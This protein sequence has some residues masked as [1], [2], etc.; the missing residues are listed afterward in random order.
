[1]VPSAVLLCAQA[2]GGKPKLSAV[3]EI[4]KKKGMDCNIVFLVEVNKVA[5]TASLFINVFILS[6]VARIMGESYGVLDETR[7]SRP[8]TS[9]VMR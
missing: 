2:A 6:I 7:I 9:L 1:L 4:V 3:K 8:G 5:K